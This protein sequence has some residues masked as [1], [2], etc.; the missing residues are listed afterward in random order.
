MKICDFFDRALG[1]CSRTPVQEADIWTQVSL[2]FIGIGA[3][4]L[5]LGFWLQDTPPN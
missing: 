4:V 3:F 1:L 2:T 5:L